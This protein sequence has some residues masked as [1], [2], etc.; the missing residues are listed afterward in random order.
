MPP[1]IPLP[2][3]SDQPAYSNRDYTLKQMQLLEQQAAREAAYE[4]ERGTMMAGRWAGLGGLATETLGSLVQ[5]RDLRAAKAE[6]QRRYDAE[7]A[8]DQRRYDL[9]ERR[10][11][12]VE[13]QQQ[14]DREKANARFDYGLIMSGPSGV[15]L[16]QSEQ[17]TLAQVNPGAMVPLTRERDE[18]VATEA[19]TPVPTE[20]LF[21]NTLRRGIT[22]EK[23]G[24][25]APLFGG[26]IGTERVTEQY[27]V[28]RRPTAA[29][30][31]QA[32]DNK[33]RTDAARAA[34]AQLAIT[35]KRAA[36][37]AVRADLRSAQILANQAN[38]DGRFL[39]AEDRAERRLLLQDQQLAK[40]IDARSQTQFNTITSQYT[41]DPIVAAADRTYVLRDTAK[42]ILAET[43]QNAN[44]SR[45]LRLAY[46]YVGAIDNYLSTVRE[47]ELENLGQLDTRVN[48]YKVELNRIA[49]KGGFLSPSNARSIAR[50]A[51][52]LGGLLEKSRQRKANEYGARARVTNPIVGG[53]FKDYLEQIAAPE[54]GEELDWK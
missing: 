41:K 48:Q 17:Q 4:R 33:A 21:A 13:A 38:A 28:G 37:A 2:Y 36:E 54:D 25:A 31:E 7:Q 12:A 1:Y 5:S 16:S 39:R 23:R 3:A 45:Q 8:E 35:N 9:Q 47:S 22:G 32:A 43:P 26:G 52:E 40:T 49:N 50:D 34:A 19:P 30:E 6:A 44:P 15:P 42:A 18:F 20:E 46:A 11:A 27:G 53:M 14:I 51:L 29:E 24:P 10:A